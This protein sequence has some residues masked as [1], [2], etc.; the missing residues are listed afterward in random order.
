MSK[1]DILRNEM[2]RDFRKGLL[3][4]FILKMLDKEDMH[5]YAMMNRI[6][7]VCGWKPS[8]GSLYPALLNLS[9]QGLIKVKV[10]AMRKVYIITPK[11]KQLVAG[12][13]QNLE[14]GLDEISRIF[15]EL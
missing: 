7:E 4:F 1:S 5:G 2:A 12:L 8:S 15:K 11:G 6:E 3:K 10:V 13:D 9:T 14:P